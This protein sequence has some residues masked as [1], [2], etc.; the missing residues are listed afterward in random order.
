MTYG[1]T[2]TEKVNKQ[3]KIHYMLYIPD[4]YEY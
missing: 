1:I 2:G 3:I 4:H